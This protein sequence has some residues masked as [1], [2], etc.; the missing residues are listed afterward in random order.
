MSP[1]QA[2]MTKRVLC[3]GS[4]IIWI[5]LEMRIK[6]EMRI[7][8]LL[9]SGVCLR[10]K[11]LRNQEKRCDMP[12]TLLRASSTSYALTILMRLSVGLTRCAH[13]L[14]KR[15]LKNISQESQEYSRPAAVV[16]PTQMRV[17]IVRLTEGSLDD[18]GSYASTARTDDRS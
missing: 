6:Q 5:K 13:S 18:S 17:S 9:H 2:G 14:V 8:C 16:D 1:D 11:N 10:D 3:A 12:A 4:G 7:L 15:Q